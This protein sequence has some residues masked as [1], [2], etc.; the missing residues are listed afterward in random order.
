MLT[1]SKHGF[2]INLQFKENRPELTEPSV[3]KTTKSD[4]PDDVIV[5]A[6]L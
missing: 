6:G 1:I 5:D 3:R 2:V 4:E